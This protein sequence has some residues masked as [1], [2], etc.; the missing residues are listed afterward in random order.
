MKSIRIMGLC[1][2]AAFALSAVVTSSAFAEKPEFLFPNGGSK[3]QFSSVDGAGK[4]ET[5]KGETVECSG[6]RDT[7]EITGAKQAS[8]VLIS[9]TGCRAKVGLEEWK[10][11]SGATAE[12]IKTFD[13]LGRLGFINKTNKEVGILFNPETGKANNPKNLFAEFECTNVKTGGKSINIKVKG[14]VIGSITPVNTLIEPSGTQ[15]FAEI[16]FKESKGKPEPKNLE[17]EAENK[18]LTLTTFT[19]K[20]KVKETGGEEGWI[21]SGALG[22]AKVFPLESMK[23]CTE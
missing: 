17:G 9:Y 14:S 11:Q 21:E 13:L 2:V 10:C 4:L 22:T 23:I 5:T 20:E 1:L 15:E 6:G 12:E 7:G 19:T 8:D 18:L 16:T 3:R